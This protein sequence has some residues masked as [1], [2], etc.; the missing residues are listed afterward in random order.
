MAPADPNQWTYTDYVCFLRS[1]GFHN[2]SGLDDFL[3]WGLDAGRSQTPRKPQRATSILL[4]FG[5]AGFRSSDMTDTTKLRVLL[6]EWIRRSPD[7]RPNSSGTGSSRRVH[8]RIIMVNNA[9]PEIIDTLGSMLKIEP[10]FFAQHLSDTAPDGLGSSHISSPLAS[11]HSRQQKDFFSIEYPCTFVT[12]DCGKD[13]NQQQLYCK[14]NYR[15][16]VEVL[17]RYGKQK[18]AVAQRKISFYMKRTLEPWICVVL[19]DPPISFFTLGA[20][21]YSTYAPSERLEVSGY[22]GGYLDFLEQKPPVTKFEHDY[23][24]CGAKS[25]CPNPF[26]DLCRYWSIMARDGRLTTSEPSVIELMRPAFQIAASEYTNFFDYIR[27]TLEFQVIST[28]L[29]TDSIKTKRALDKAI[30]LDSILSRYKPMLTK[31]K[32]YLSTDPELVEDYRALLIGLHH[33]RAECD[34]QMQH[35]LAVTQVQDSSSMSSTATE[36]TRQADYLRILTIVALIYAP[37]AIGCAIFTLPHDFAPAAHYMY[38][39]IPALVVVTLLFVLLV[40]PEARDPLS[41]LR[42]LICGKLTRK[43]VMASIP[44]RQRGRKSGSIADIEKY[45]ARFDEI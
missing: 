17:N 3:Q 15:R 18:V 45:A 20:E 23:R 41:A 40:L 19:V 4:E 5:K 38:Y 30:L 22:Q 25:M 2:L 39:L 24:S 27:S 26:D 9:N 13:V 16:K 32:T 21:S 31:T 8:G 6:K 33:Y 1:H 44:S 28:E 7:N 14:G 12:K 35:I 42:G 43:K 10:A 29:T 36:S 37:F 34:S 11:H